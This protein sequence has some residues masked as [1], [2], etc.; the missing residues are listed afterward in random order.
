MKV[1][2]IDVDRSPMGAGGDAER[3]CRLYGGSCQGP[4]LSGGPEERKLFGWCKRML[5][6]VDEMRWQVWF[7]LVGVVTTFSVY[8]GEFN[9][10]VC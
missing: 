7:E 5:R 3:S 8:F 2:T 1:A 6:S 10:V 9:F 4:M